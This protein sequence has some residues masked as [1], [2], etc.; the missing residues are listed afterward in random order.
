M[1]RLR[2]QE[3]FTLPE[4]LIGVTMSMIIALAGFALLETAMKKTGETADRVEATQRGRQAMDVI[5]RELRSQVCLPADQLGPTFATAQPAV[6][7]ASPTQV[8]F[9]SDMTDG[10]GA[11]LNRVEKRVLVYD[12]AKKTLVEE[13]YKTTGVV[14]L[15]W[16]STGS[17][18]TLA[19]NVVPEPNFS[20]DPAKPTIFRY[21]AFGPAT[22]SEPPKTNLELTN[23]GPAD[24]G[25]IARIDVAFVRRSGTEK[26]TK[27]TAGSLSLRSQVY[28][29]AADPNDPAPY[30]TCV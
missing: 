9:F 17:K 2:R 3:G 8:T 10:T 15:T 23:P 5:T 14:P 28:I 26:V 20:P 11:F 24:I 1:R 22:A 21:Y 7:V 4:L 18:K 30:P 13:R 29:R 27:T 6:A 12:P 16:K 19:T 25:R